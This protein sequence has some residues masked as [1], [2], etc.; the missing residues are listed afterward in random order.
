MEHHRKSAQRRTAARPEGPDT[1]PPYEILDGILELYVEQQLSAEE[2]VERGYEEATVRGVQRRVD[3]NE[4]K[5][6]QA[7]PGIRVTTKAFGTGRRMPIAQ[8]FG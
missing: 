8:V 3:R 7:A 6:Q 4:W 1:L 5:R 2:I